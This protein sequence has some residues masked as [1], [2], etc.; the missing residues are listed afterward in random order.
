MWYF[1]VKGAPRPRGLWRDMCGLIKT[2]LSWSMI[3]I[4][5]EDHHTDILDGCM[6]SPRPNIIMIWKYCKLDTFFHDKRAHKFKIRFLKF[7]LQCLEKYWF[8][9]VSFLRNT[10]VVSFKINKQKKKLSDQN[11]KCPQEASIV[12]W[13]ASGNGS[14]WFLV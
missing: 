1:M 2:Y 8:C 7:L 10:I 5:T 6:L 13:R 14:R 3:R 12:K 11:G 4:L 9:V